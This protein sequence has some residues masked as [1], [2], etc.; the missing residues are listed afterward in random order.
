MAGDGVVTRQF[1]DAPLADALVLGLE[2]FGGL[3]PLLVGE[4]AERLVDG[5]LVAARQVDE[6]LG[7]L[8][9]REWAEAAE[10]LQAEYESV[11]ERRVPELAGD[12]PVA[13]HLKNPPEE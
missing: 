2:H 8:A 13:C 5:P 7:R 11:C 9:D 6:A 1:G 3:R 12:H 10:M 4:Q